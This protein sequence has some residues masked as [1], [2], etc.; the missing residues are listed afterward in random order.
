MVQPMSI[1]LL[2]NVSMLSG[3]NMDRARLRELLDDY[4][5]EEIIENS[6]L[7]VIDALEYMVTYGIITLRSEDGEAEEPA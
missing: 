3:G 6:D 2:L 7:E 1:D 5:L 4:T